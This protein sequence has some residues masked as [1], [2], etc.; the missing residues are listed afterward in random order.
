LYRTCKIDGIEWKTDQ[1][2]L[3]LDGEELSK[4]KTK[5]TPASPS[6]KAINGRIISGFMEEEDEQY[7]ILQEV[8][9]KEEIKRK[10]F[11]NGP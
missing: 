4:A 8:V 9:P 3:E 7:V 6:N 10:K 2:V 5:T 11:D 1:Y